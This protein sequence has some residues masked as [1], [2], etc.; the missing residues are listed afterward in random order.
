MINSQMLDS[1][2]QSINK[3]ANTNLS[4]EGVEQYARDVNVFK[5][6]N[7]DAFKNSK[8]FANSKNAQAYYEFA[9]TYINENGKQTFKNNLERKLTGTAQEVD[10]L[11]DKKGS[12]DR[13]FNKTKLIGA[14]QANAPGI[15]GLNT[16][17]LTNKSVGVSIK[18]AKSNK[19]LVTNAKDVIKA[20]EKGSLEPTDE[21]VG[22]KGMKTAV[23]KY[24]DKAIEVANDNN[25]TEK[26]K[27]LQSAKENL[28]VSE[29][30]TKNTTKASTDRLMEKMKNGKA[31][32]NVTLG[33]V[34]K[35]MKQGAVIGAA[36]NVSIAS[37]KGYL[38]YK[39]GKVTKEEAFISIGKEGIKGALLGG[40]MAGVSIFIPGGPIG[41]FAGMA[42]GIY[43]GKVTQNILEEIYGEG[44]FRAILKSYEYIQASVI[45]LSELLEVIKENEMIIE[46]NHKKIKQLNQ[47]INKKKI[48]IEDMLGDLK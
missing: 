29:L 20:I 36:V 22:S 48:K 23:N 8:V 32:P 1:V 5:Q 17:R 7:V 10:W 9:E 35:Q 34:G 28:K 4:F 13:V 41:F 2:A 40:A 18:T 16:N 39:N 12:L 30:G 47:N 33:E 24:L 19:G 43:F 21:V 11:R 37:I 27:K 44:S 38:D 31:N 45:K 6:L 25:D 3:V 15:D 26:L 14:E 42:I 46:K